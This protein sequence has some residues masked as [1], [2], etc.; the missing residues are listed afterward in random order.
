VNLERVGRSLLA[1][2]GALGVIGM[3]LADSRAQYG[4]YLGLSGCLIMVA[5]A[6]LLLA[7]RPAAR[8]ERRTRPA[9]RSSDRAAT[10]ANRVPR[11]R[12]AVTPQSDTPAHPGC[13]AADTR[14]AVSAVGRDGTTRAA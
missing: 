13:P 1:L 5:L 7:P 11:Q 8:V 2:A 6:V 3:A 10:A 9:R 4:R 14:P 12:T